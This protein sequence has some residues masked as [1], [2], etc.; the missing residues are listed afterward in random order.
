MYTLGNAFIWNMYYYRLSTNIIGKD[1]HV[2]YD[3]YNTNL[4]HSQICITQPLLKYAISSH[5]HGNISS[6]PVKQDFPYSDTNMI[7]ISY[8]K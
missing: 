5:I 8:I 6:R 3:V 2:F 1:L 4:I 7:V